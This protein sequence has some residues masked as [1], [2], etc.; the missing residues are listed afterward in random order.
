ME[1]SKL[2]DLRIFSLTA[3]STTSLSV[4]D[5][6]SSLKV[7]IARTMSCR[8]RSCVIYL[9]LWFICKSLNAGLFSVYQIRFFFFE[10]RIERLGSFLACASL[11]SSPARHRDDDFEGAL[12]D[13]VVAGSLV[14]LF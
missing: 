9:P 11:T 4:L 13:V 6:L 2:L 8:S 10:T 12:N 7:E 5:G 1:T 3:A 14:D